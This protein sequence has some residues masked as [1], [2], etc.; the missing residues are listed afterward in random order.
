MDK[1]LFVSYSWKAANVEDR[2]RVVNLLEDRGYF[3]FKDQS[4]DYKSPLFG[5]NKE[6]WDIIEK[7]IMASDIVL[8]TA[9]VYSS[10]SDSI[11]KEIML[12]KK[13]NKPIIGVKPFGNTYVSQFVRENVEEQNIVNH[14]TESIVTAIR[15][16]W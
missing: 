9:G 10:Y 14:N 11:K 8:V 4:I 2:N 6:V 7:R 1:K 13:H 5:T 16:N 12:A 3:N 15:N